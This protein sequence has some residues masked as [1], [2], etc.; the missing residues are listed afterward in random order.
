MKEENVIKKEEVE[1]KEKE[2]KEVLVVVV[3]RLGV[4]DSAVEL[5]I[6]HTPQF[7]P[8]LAR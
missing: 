7:H 5:R 8:T 2:D 4:L 6:D 1:V 3:L